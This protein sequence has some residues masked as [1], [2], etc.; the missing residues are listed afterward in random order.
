MRWPMISSAPKGQPAVRHCGSQ[1][2]AVFALVRPPCFESRRALH[3]ANDPKR[4]Q[5][6][7]CIK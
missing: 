6:S 7:H 4:S 5:C 2:F 3:D 1:L